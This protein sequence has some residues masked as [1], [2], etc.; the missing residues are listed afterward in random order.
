MLR[1]TSD[2]DIH[3]EMIRGLLRRLP[4]LILLAWESTP[5]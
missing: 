4:G 3:G 1:L 5:Q 2:A